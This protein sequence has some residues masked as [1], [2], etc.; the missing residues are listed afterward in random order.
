MKPIPFRPGEMTHLEKA[1]AIELSLKRLKILELARTG[2]SVAYQ[3]AEEE[4]GIGFWQ[5]VEQDAGFVTVEDSDGKKW[6][7]LALYTP[8]LVEHN[9]EALRMAFVAKFGEFVLQ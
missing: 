5:L 7:K 8:A 9:A 4:H 1:R 3:Q 2:S 6:P